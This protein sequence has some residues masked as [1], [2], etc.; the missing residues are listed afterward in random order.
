MAPQEALYQL[1]SSRNE[2]IRQAFSPSPHTDPCDSFP[3]LLA[4]QVVLGLRRSRQRVLCS[5]TSTVISDSYHSS[6]DNVNSVSLGV[7]VAIKRNLLLR[8][9][10]HAKPQIKCFRFC[11]VLVVQKQTV[12]LLN[13]IACILLLI[14][15]CFQKLICF[16]VSGGWWWWRGEA[17]PLSELSGPVKYDIPNGFKVSAVLSA[18][19]GAGSGSVHSLLPPRPSPWVRSTPSLRM[20]SYVPLCSVARRERSF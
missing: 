7:T 18:A 2:C 14:A 4:R 15:F 6:D 17:L 11:A 19:A 9:G 8:Y 5:T 12:L 3:V 20:T 13:P 10:A 1:S 16:C